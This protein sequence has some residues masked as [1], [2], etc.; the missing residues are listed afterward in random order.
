MLPKQVVRY[1]QLINEGLK[2]KE[3]E[4]LFTSLK[5]FPTPFKGI[6]YVPLEIERKGGFIGKPLL[7][8]S[9]ATE[10]YLKSKNFYFSCV[11]A[12]E[13]YGIQWQPSGQV[14]IVNDKLSK[15]INLK[16]RIGRNKSKKTARAKKIAKLL[17]LYGYEI[18][19]HKAKSFRGCRF[20]ETPY[21][22][23]AARS[24]IRIDK[25]RFRC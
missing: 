7:V 13:Q 5:L 21:G 24:Q 22:R 3:I 23:F 9:R 8:L 25:K 6:Y 10:H 15:R 18:L 12:E 16:E 2:K 17:S 11:T 14:H 19:L 4:T 20:R 1:E